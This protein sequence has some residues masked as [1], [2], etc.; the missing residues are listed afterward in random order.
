MLHF[1][2]VGEGNIQAVLDYNSRYFE[3]SE[4]SSLGAHVTCHS[5]VRAVK[6][7]TVVMEQGIGSL[8]LL[9]FAQVVEQ[10]FQRDREI[11]S[12]VLKQAFG[13]VRTSVVCNLA[14]SVLDT[15]DNVVE[16]TFLC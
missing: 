16:G 8:K 1:V 6:D 10:D 3:Q 13:E 4:T 15:L 12:L 5:K 14:P 11:S 7:A 2:V 9:H